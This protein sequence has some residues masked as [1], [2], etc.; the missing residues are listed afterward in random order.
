MTDSTNSMSLRGFPPWRVSGDPWGMICMLG[1]LSPHARE[2]EETCG[3]RLSRAKRKQHL[4]L[5]KQGIE[6]C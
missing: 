2:V 4:R 5:I 1:R 6:N 3:S